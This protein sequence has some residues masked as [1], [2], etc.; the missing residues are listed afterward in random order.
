MFIWHV[1][2]LKASS[3]LPNASNSGETYFSEH[4]YITFLFTTLNWPWVHVSLLLSAVWSGRHGLFKI[5]FT[6]VPS[7]SFPVSPRFFPLFCSLYF[8]LALY[9]LN[10]WNRLH[11]YGLICV[12]SFTRTPQI[13]LPTFWSWGRGGVVV[14]ALDFRFEGRW[15]AA[16]SLPSCCFLRQE[17]L[18]HIHLSLPRFINGY[19]WHTAGG[20]P[21][22]DQHPIQGKVALLS[23]ASC[24]KNWE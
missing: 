11:L 6:G 2:F 18:P 10:A 13:S 21:A 12:S 1:K 7:S 5:N 20:N 15:L 19:R 17:T 8:S 4:N 16:Q 23:V 3:T 9:Y 22:M 14:S 24:Y